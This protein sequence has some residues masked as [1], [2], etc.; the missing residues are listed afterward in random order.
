MLIRQVVSGEFSQP[1]QAAVLGNCLKSH[2]RSELL[3]K[4]VVRVRHRF[5]QVHV[6]AA[7]H[8]EHGVASDDIFFQG[9]QRDGRLNRR[10]R[11]VAVSESNFLIHDREDAA[12][13]S[14]WNPQTWELR[15]IAQRICER[16]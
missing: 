8:L 14:W 15:D 7:P 1:E 4:H 13:P 3:K 11:N 2:P 6:L 12:G 10:A 5:R 16:A 9:S